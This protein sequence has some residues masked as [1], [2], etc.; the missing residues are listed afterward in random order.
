M[1]EVVCL[2]GWMEGI[3]LGLYRIWDRGE[4]IE[5]WLVCFGSVPWSVTCPVF[6]LVPSLL[7]G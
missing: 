2:Q 1:C 4:L 5:H 7:A 6:C 3:R